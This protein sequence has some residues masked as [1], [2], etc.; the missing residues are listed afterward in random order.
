MANLIDQGDILLMLAPVFATLLNVL[1]H[2]A[3]MRLRIFG[4]HLGP[5]IVAFLVGLVA[6]VTI[7]GW[8]ASWRGS[9]AVELVALEMFNSVSY[10]ALGYSYFT[11]INLAFTSLRI[12]I[13]RELVDSP[14]GAL[15]ATRLKLLYN[16]DTILGK[17]LERLVAWGQIHS[18][19]DRYYIA[20][21]PAFLI[22]DRQIRRVRGL[23]LGATRGRD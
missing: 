6:V 19:G 8:I 17:R 15:P 4:A 10:G 22:L 3:M 2:I 14:G 23:L 21:S 9:S 20:G 12:R 11:A 7:T 13:C 18:S 5:I 1:L 16:L